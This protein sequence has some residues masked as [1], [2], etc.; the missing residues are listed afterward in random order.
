MFFSG[1][2]CLR[3][4]D[5]NRRHLKPQLA[6]LA[7]IARC[8]PGGRGCGPRR[9]SFQTTSTSPGRSARDAAVESQSVVAYAGREVV[10]DVA[11]IDLTLT[12]SGNDTHLI[13]GTTH[14][15]IGSGDPSDAVNGV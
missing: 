8:W 13:A 4:L 9:S 1:V 7:V 11:G 10:V 3:V 14:T 2:L 15:A 5:L 12:R 6:S